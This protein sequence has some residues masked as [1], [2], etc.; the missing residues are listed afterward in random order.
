MKL[1]YVGMWFLIIMGIVLVDV[2]VMMKLMAPAKYG[3]AATR[4]HPSE[5]VKQNELFWKYVNSHNCSR[6][7]VDTTRAYSCDNGWWE[8]SEL[9]RVAEGRYP[10]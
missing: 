5:L 1:C 3:A 10:H 8:E 2:P 6:L 9:I 4:Y 7:I